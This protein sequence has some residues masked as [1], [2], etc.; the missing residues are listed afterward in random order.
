[1]DRRV[2][3]GVLAA[4]GAAVG[5]IAVLFAGS[6]P[7]I[8]YAAIS[9]LCA[10]TMPVYALC[11]ALAADNTELTVVEV[12]SGMLLANGIGSVFGPIVA[13]QLMSSVSPNMFFAFSA[14]C[15]GGAAIWTFHRYFA[16]ERPRVHET[17]T[18]M[19]PRTTQ[20]VAELAVEE[21]GATETASSS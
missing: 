20:A 12:T 7:V 9:L 19:L 11:V 14:V 15:L 2:V 16:V 3:I 6:S 17:H 13:A 10:A 18:P 4:L 21:G 1:M 5:S 8:L